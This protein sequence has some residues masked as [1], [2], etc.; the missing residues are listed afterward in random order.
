[1]RSTLLAEIN[2]C[3][4]FW[5][6]HAYALPSQII[7]KG[8]CFLTTCPPQIRNRYSRF[9]ITKIVSAFCYFEKKFLKNNS[10][11]RRIF[12][13][14]LNISDSKNS[15]LG[16]AIVLE[17]NLETERLTVDQIL[18]AVSH[19]L[20][21]VV[22]T[23]GIYYSR[24]DDERGLLYIYIEIEKK[25]GRGFSSLDI[26]QLKSLLGKEVLES[27]QSLTPSLF[28]IRNEEE[29]FR[30]IVQMSRELNANH[31]IPLVTISFQKQLPNGFLHFSVV[32]LRFFANESLELKDLSYKLPKSLKWI[33]EITTELEK[34]DPAYA[35][36][37][38]L[39]TVEVESSL[40][41][42]KDGS[43]DLREARA[44]VAKGI[45]LMIGEFRDYNGG[46]FLKQDKQ[47]KEIKD[48]LEDANKMQI[49]SLFY[50]LTPSVF[51][52]F[53]LPEAG[54]ACAS[55]ILEAKKTSLSRRR[56][57]L[58]LEKNEERFSVSVIKTTEESLKNRIQNEI[59][60]IA[61]PLHQ[62]GYT[63]QEYDSEYLFALIYQFPRDHAWLDSL[64]KNLLT[65]QQP[66]QQEKR[67]LK[68][69]FQD[70]DPVT[71]NPHIG[72]DLRCRSI[73]K[74]LFEGLTRSGPGGKIEFA[75]AKSVDICD[76][77]IT[78]IFSL[79][80]MQWSNGEE[81]TA[82]HFEKTWKQAIQSPSCLRPDIFFVL[83]NARK[84]RFGQ[85]SVHDIGVKA[86]DKSTLHVT[87]EYPA[88]YFLQ[89]VSHPLFFPLYE[90][91]GEPFV[92][93][94]PFTLHLWKRDHS[95]I[96]IK[97]PYYWDYDNVKLDG[98]DI[99]I[100]R[101]PYLAYE[102]YQNGKLDWIGGP[103]S[104]LPPSIIV[105][106]EH[107]LK[108]FDTSGIA[109][110]YCNLDQSLLASSKI[111]RALSYSLDRKRICKRTF[112]GTPCQTHIPTGLSQIQ[113]RTVLEQEIVDLFKEGLNELRCTQKSLFPLHLFHSHISGQKELASEIQEQWQE[114]F[115]IKIEK[116]EAPWN[117]F[118]QKLDNRLLHFGACYRHPYYHDPMY[119]FNIFY[120]STNIHNAFGWH[121]EIFNRLINQ[122]RKSP[123]ETTYLKQAEE[124]LQLQM[125]VI[126]LHLV[127]YHYLV[128][129]Q[130][131]GINI[132]HSGD[133]DFKWI[134]FKER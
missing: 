106:T 113:P 79:R 124:E 32:V 56:P 24:Q 45:E 118:S 65:A 18:R 102:R 103:F 112:Q 28:I 104:L 22:L 10:L 96:L 60:T 89:M 84:A 119:F 41:S 107:E 98:I 109:W 81:L 27:I 83:K 20:P 76:Q 94:G 42:K 75:A 63:V 55:L 38:N 30:N 25:K 33:P 49:D 19:Q 15:A 6:N 128:R 115:G 5:S 46:L 125:P 29:I 122:L 44:Y 4:Q 8:L 116:I 80:H 51:Q 2:A 35:K 14:L 47:L 1:M 26:K 130:I 74:A 66:V 40:F 61:F 86:L 21:G 110:I 48:A 37:A 43:I 9:Y 50:S 87:L 36:Q 54:K 64:K 68:I 105:Q 121:S 99:S 70:G 57:Y 39:I 132:C 126:P 69:N 100:L 72:L 34:V 114:K 11:R 97:N 52:S 129:E 88:P 134:Y 7:E 71:L 127:S 23:P 12:F 91:H 82:F 95:I 59:S 111:R 101:D 67:F 62:F 73:Q 58:F 77:G 133:V 120:D 93:S 117:T 78:Y 92:F 3:A 85:A 131:E 108:K 31:D 123:Q 13:R 90:D 17:A 16:I 53:L